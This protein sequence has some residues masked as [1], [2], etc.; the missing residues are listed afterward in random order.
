M[1]N[2]EAEFRIQKRLHLRSSDSASDLLRFHVLANVKLIF[3]REVRD[4]I[5]RSADAVHRAGVAD[6]CCIR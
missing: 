6:A 5:A 3:L 2:S 4:Q 1:Q